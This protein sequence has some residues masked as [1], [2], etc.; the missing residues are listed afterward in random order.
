VT[1]GPGEIRFFDRHVPALPIGDYTIDA[2]Q[3]VAPS[4]GANGH[5]FSEDFTATQAFSVAGPR[6]ALPPDDVYSVFPPPNAGGV[7]G[8]FL[9]HVVLTKRELPW[10][11]DVFA[12]GH[13]PWLAVLL[14][15]P[16]DDFGDG[17]ALPA[18]ADK[19]GNR[20]GTTA[21]AAAR[22]Y[23][24][25]SADTS[26]LWPD[27]GDPEWYEADTLD[28]VQCSV[29]DL[30]PKAFAALVPAV[31]DL[32]E[33]AHV[34]HINAASKDG[35]VLRIAGDGW[36]S[37]VVGNRLPAVAAA[38][39]ALNVA[40]LVA[41][42]GLV[43]YVQ[44]TKSI[45]DGI[46]RVRMLALQSWAFSAV[47]DGGESFSELMNG[48][49]RDPAGRAK[50]T[51]F[52]LPGR[53]A[54]AV[55]TALQDA[56]TA[57]ERGYV[58]LEYRTRQGEQTAT[59]YRGPLSPVPVADLVAPKP[60]DPLAWQPYP[61]ASA[62]ITYDPDYG[63][64]DVSYA[65]AWETG[66]L[67]AL[68]D[69]SFSEALVAW[70][71][72]GH[73]LIDVILERGGDIPKLGL[74]PTQPDPAAERQLLDALR[75]YEVT[76]AF[77]QYLLDEFAAE[78]KPGAADGAAPP[79]PADSSRPSPV[80]SPKTIADLLTDADVQDAIRA[81]GARETGLIADWLAKR[82]LLDGVPF[83]AL[84]AHPGLL[85]PES[86]RF[87]YL[88][89]SWLD[90]LLEGALSVGQS[91]SRDLLYQGLMKEVLWDTTL[92]AVRSLRARLVADCGGPAVAAAQSPSTMTGLLLRSAAVTN[93]PG[94]E[95]HGYTQTRAQDD[96]VPD[97][98]HELPLLRLER[99]SADVMLCLWPEV[100][101][102]VSID[103]PHEGI[104]FGFE[105]ANAGGAPR[106]SGEDLIVY[107]RSLA[108]SGFGE[109]L[110]PDKSIDAKALAIVDPKTRVVGVGALR[111]QLKSALSAGHD[112]AP[113]ELAIEMVKVPEQG[114]FAYRAPT[115]NGGSG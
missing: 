28:R 104:A 90:T 61:T 75:G 3:T 1:V 13:T 15:G 5:V 56:N 53:A 73:R 74:D 49:V 58:P 57:L 96:P 114:V 26:I 108:D 2:Y 111:G 9:P 92:D 78:M 76:D 16:G 103:E 10:E 55:P 95:V 19:D 14:F 29:V 47:D 27:L 39:G 85:P 109:L 106:N 60:G 20:L 86:V 38:P 33:L 32:G 68:A 89:P 48:L 59:W 113:R 42:D 66:R 64:F 37:V 25:H 67:L 4:D 23:D 34:R 72:E 70:Q 80:P 83:E 69:R 40:H 21:L 8:Q 93:W 112:L 102:V 6:Y 99:L 91:T 43:P 30:S 35:G 31:A 115:A 94:L 11:R 101:A 77:A 110:G 105:D 65:V 84:V 63:M 44:G 71:R 97:V 54:E 45:S 107:L 41:L 81:I 51:S 46:T 36:Y 17:P 88:D 87:F 62:A 100:P 98:E 24:D 22:L 82:Y 7:F 79:L 12:D 18:V 50:S 52:S